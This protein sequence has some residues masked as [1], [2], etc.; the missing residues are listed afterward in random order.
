MSVIV[1]GRRVEEKP[2]EEPARTEDTAKKPVKS[3][4][5]AE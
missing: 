2:K 3:R 4:K 1:A 5:K